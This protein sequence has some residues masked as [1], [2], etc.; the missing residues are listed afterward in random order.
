MSVLRKM[1]PVCLLVLLL[2]ACGSEDNRPTVVTPP[3][4]PMPEVSQTPTEAP[5]PSPEAQVLSEAAVRTYFS[6]IT[7]TYNATFLRISPEVLR[8]QD[9]FNA[10]V[11]RNNTLLAKKKIINFSE[12]GEYLSRA[13][14]EELTR[15]IDDAQDDPYAME[16]PYFDVHDEIYF[17][18]QY[19]D[20]MQ[21]GV[22]EIWG[23]GALDIEALLDVYD[24]DWAFYRSSNGV[25][26]QYH[27]LGD[28]VYDTIPYW[29]IK[30]CSVSSDT[31]VLRTNCIGVSG[32]AY[33][34]E[35][36]YAI[37]YTD[38][39]MVG[40]VVTE[41]WSQ[42]NRGVSFNHAATLVGI[43][44][45]TLGE[46]VFTVAATSEGLHL[47]SLVT[48]PFRD[49][50]SKLVLPDE[51]L[52]WSYH[53]EVDAP[54]G[55]ELR[56]GPGETYEATVRLPHQMHITELATDG[57]DWL[58]VGGTWKEKEY[59]GWLRWEDVMFYGGMAKPVIYLY[60]E[61]PT[62]VCVEVSFASGGFTCT[63]PDYGDG[64]RV[65]AQPDGTLTNYAD[66]RE[67][68]YLYWEGA[69]DV[70]YDMDQGF[71][72]RGEDTAAFLQE[73]LAFMGLMPREY[74]E[75]IVYWLPLM[76]ENP[77]NLVTFQTTAYTDHVQLQIDPKP[78]SLLRVYMVFQPLETY[79][80]VA[81]QEL[82]SFEREGFTVVEWGGIEYGK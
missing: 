20:E 50:S 4:A 10:Y 28:E 53:C 31:A 9:W 2:A 32:Y 45:S 29:G 8:E 59:F 22:D 61:T 46:Y 11:F 39:R 24:V 47:E 1:L 37:D 82:V 51:F 71:V 26:L 70:D 5:F 77:Y 80:L 54:E 33:F 18:V 16:A 43:D 41:E 56:T 27:Y 62:D 34:T 25:L 17:T 55:A 69:G 23:K 12:L 7:E 13:D 49:F 44:R 75:F 6:H 21:Q 76:H 40:G 81:P 14:A 63:Y 68:S 30:D 3:P 19:V 15:L 36:G 35:G 38:E 66:G 64:W 48:Q 52:E 79:R 67:Y 78:D 74:N 57:G 72:V 58:L 60:P 42:K 73:K 65:R